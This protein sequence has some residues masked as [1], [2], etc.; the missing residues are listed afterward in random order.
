MSTSSSCVSP[1]SS[2]VPPFQPGRR[3]PGPLGG[4]WRQRG[5]D[6]ELLFALHVRACALTLLAREELRPLLRTD[7]APPEPEDRK[8]GAGAAMRLLMQ[9]HAAHTRAAELASAPEGGGSG[10]AP[11]VAAQ[12]QRGLAALALAEATAFAVLNDDPFPVAVA[13]QTNR[14][15]REWMYRSAGVGVTRAR[16][17]GRV[18]VAAAG[19]A[20]SAAGALKNVAGLEAGVGV[21]C[22]SLYM[23]CRAKAARF[24]G[25]AAEGEGN[26]GEGIAWIQAAKKEL[27]V[28]EKPLPRVLQNWKDKKEAERIEKGRMR[29][30]YDAGRGDEGRV[31]DMVEKKWAKVNDT[32]SISKRRYKVRLGL[33]SQQMTM[34]KIPSFQ[35]LLASMPSGRECQQPTTFSIPLLPESALAALRGPPEPKSSG[36]V[37]SDESGSNEGDSTDPVGAFPGTA[38]NYS[39]GVGS[40]TIF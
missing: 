27:G 25:I 12:T 21:Y 6:G 1:T 17:L 38:K 13:E 40:S 26:T 16:I 7:V 10:G 4:R 18:C 33:T 31:L 20:S 29:W 14:H 15:S 5:V 32:V 39:A 3:A 2:G 30:G 37:D 8:R 11:D 22:D 36:W 35:A 28:K 9:A 19:H 23:V 34:Q 24:N